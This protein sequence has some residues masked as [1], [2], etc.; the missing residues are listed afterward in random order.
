MTAINSN[1]AIRGPITAVPVVAGKG[2]RLVADTEN[3]RIVAEADETVLYDA[4]TAG[5]Q[6]GTGVAPSDVTVQLSESI[7][8]FDRIRIYL[9]EKLSGVIEFRPGAATSSVVANSHKYYHTSPD[10]DSNTNIVGLLISLVENDTTKLRFR[11]GFSVN[12]ANAYRSGADWGYYILFK[13]V[14]VDRISSN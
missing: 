7:T 1:R 4:G 6:P 13:I 12:W 9:G 11:C 5:Y 2:V 14:G 8:N 10:D 3:N